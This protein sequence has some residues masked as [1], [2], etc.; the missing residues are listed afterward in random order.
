MAN[1]IIDASFNI[2]SLNRQ[3]CWVFWSA[4]GK[5]S[6]WS[7]PYSCFVYYTLIYRN[8]EDG[9][10]DFIYY[11]TTPSTVLL[12]RRR[13]VATN[14]RLSIVI[15]SVRPKNLYLRDAVVEWL[16]A[17]IEYKN[18]LYRVVL[19]SLTNYYLRIFV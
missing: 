5:K 14:V 2:D 8:A 10:C 6:Y 12:V 3:E 18:I 11:Y 19:L 9:M 1:V 13:D 17:Y 16:Y 7:V 4:I 15:R